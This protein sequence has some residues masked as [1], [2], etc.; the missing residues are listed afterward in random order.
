MTQRKTQ[1]A[2]AFLMLESFSAGDTARFFNGIVEKYGEDATVIL[3][4]NYNE[5][6]VRYKVKKNK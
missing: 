4:F 5:I 1:D 6:E 3:D 2:V